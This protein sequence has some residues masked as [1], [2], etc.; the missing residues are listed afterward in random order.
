MRD[1]TDLSFDI[2]DE[3]ESQASSDEHGCTQQRESTMMMTIKSSDNNSMFAGSFDPAH[4]IREA[5]PS[6]SNSFGVSYSYSNNTAIMPVQ[7]TSLIGV[8]N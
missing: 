4:K 2:A 3:G 6:A 5:L 7:N 8:S 1:S